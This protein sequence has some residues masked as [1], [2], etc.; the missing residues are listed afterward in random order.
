MALTP[1]PI[2]ASDGR[3]PWTSEGG[4]EGLSLGRS[5]GATGGFRAMGRVASDG[6]VTFDRVLLVG[7]VGDGTSPVGAEGG[8]C[9]DTAGMVL[10]VDSHLAHSSGCRLMWDWSSSSNVRCRASVRGMLT[11]P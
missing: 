7:P 8:N 9:T 5:S 4:R 3:A 11:H 1:A 2:F 10:D 6:S